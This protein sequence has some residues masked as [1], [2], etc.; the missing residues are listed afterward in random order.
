MFCE[1][2]DILHRS[3]QENDSQQKPQKHIAGQTP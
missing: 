1:V 3:F 2:G